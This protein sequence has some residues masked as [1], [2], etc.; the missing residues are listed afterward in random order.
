MGSPS[1]GYPSIKFGT[2]LYTW[3]ERGTVRVKCLGQEHKF[4][5]VPGQNWKLGLLDTES[6]I[7]TI[8]LTK[9]TVLKKWSYM[10]ESSFEFL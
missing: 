5:N 2:H 3:V 1:E 9:G 8:I 4:T 6:N 10:L 7:L